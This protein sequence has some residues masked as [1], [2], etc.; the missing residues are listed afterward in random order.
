MPCPVASIQRQREGTGGSVLSHFHEA[1]EIGGTLQPNERVFS[2]IRRSLHVSCR[3][4]RKLIWQAGTTNVV[5]ACA[6]PRFFD[7]PNW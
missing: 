1:R 3:D 4:G 7:A 2:A 5:P 6:R